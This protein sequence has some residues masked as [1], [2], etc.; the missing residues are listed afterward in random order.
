MNC[1]AIPGEQFRFI[2]WSK[3]DRSDT[4][5]VDLIH[6]CSCRDWVCRHAQYEKMTGRW[7]LCKHQRAAWE[8]IQDG[9]RKRYK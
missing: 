3:E 9:I 1:E 8:I 7:Y 4:K 5:M 2:C 6:G